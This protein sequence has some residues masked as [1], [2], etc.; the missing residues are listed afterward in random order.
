MLPVPVRSVSMSR[1]SRSAARAARPSLRLPPWAACLLLL[2][3]PAFGQSSQYTAPGGDVGSGPPTAV[4]IEDQMEAARWRL[5]PVRLA[6]W[7]GLRGL[8]WEQDVFV[9]EDE[10]ETSDL[11]GTVGAGL[12]AYLPTGPKVFWIVQ[13]MPEYVWWLDLDERNELTGRYGGGV[14]ADLNRLRLA[15]DVHS[16]E[17]QAV[18][19]IES[20]QQVLVER[21]GVSAAAAVDLSA[22]FV[23]AAAFADE[24][25]DQ[26]LP[27]AEAGESIFSRLDRSEQTASAELR[28]EPGDVLSVGVGVERT[29][30][31]FAAGARD[32]SST[33]T[34][35][36]LRFGL[37]G[38]RISAEAQIEQ[39]ELEPEPGSVLRP[40][41]EETGRVRIELAPGWRF[42]FGLYASR[43]LTY[44]IDGAWSHLLDERF[45]ATVAAPF[46]ERLTLSAFGETGTADFEPLG[47]TLPRSDDLTAYGAD[48]QY[49]LGEWLS[50]RAGFHQVEIESDLPEFDRDYLRITST[51]VLSTGDW[52]WR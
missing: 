38:N 8:T 2:A 19:S 37:T 30:T 45:G 18:V 31:E 34:S 17:E 51:F 48:A 41:D 27:G 33:G 7:L 46:G 39:R 29:D 36:Y 35:P 32:L 14:V 4:E 21:R 47:A 50:Y 1:V 42:T 13:A 6:P 10:G 5:G 3:A 23:L 16:V 25:H 52:I 12:T 26:R 20:P 44:A 43:H 28:Y 15:A 40:V 24:E 22:A 11:T 49:R 9:E